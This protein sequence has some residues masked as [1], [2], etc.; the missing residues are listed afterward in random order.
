VV[1]RRA[2][3]DADPLVASIADAARRRLELLGVAREEIER[4]ARTGTP[5]RALEV[6]SPVA[7]H[8]TRRNAVAGLYVEPGTGLF[9][10][11]DLSTVWVLADV[12]EYE[13]ERVAV[14]AAARFEPASRRG[15]PFTGRVRFLQP[16]IDPETRTLRARVE[17]RNQG[18]ALRPGMYGDVVIELPPAKG[19]IVPADAVVDTGETQYV[20]IALEGGRFVPRAV[21]TGAESN[22]SVEVLEG[23]REGEE[24]VTT[25]NFLIDSES[26]L[27]AAISGQAPAARERARSTAPA[28]GGE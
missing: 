20:F 21:R 6:R 9:E 5:A 10:V 11:A 22:G 17:L 2:G 24:V 26:R 13:V 27:Q 3:E 12:Y 15:S 1:E 23:L 16:T 18:L 19:L 8:V 14:G 7:G 25:A 28:G 4:L